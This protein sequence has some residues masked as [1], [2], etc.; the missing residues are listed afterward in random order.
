[1][2]FEPSAESINTLDDWYFE[3][4][5][6]DEAIVVADAVAGHLSSATAPDGF[7]PGATGWSCYW[8]GGFHKNWSLPEW[9]EKG[10]KHREWRREWEA[11]KEQERRD[12]DARKARQR[13]QS[14]KQVRARKRREADAKWR[15]RDAIIKRIAHRNH[16]AWRLT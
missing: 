14:V 15:E 9:L 13:V 10:R 16:F 1:M 5:M 7:P 8:H 3:Q 12:R 11:Q 2:N 4:H 6:I